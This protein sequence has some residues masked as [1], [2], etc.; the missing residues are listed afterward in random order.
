M[1]QP[2]F[3]IE[4]WE[5]FGRRIAGRCPIPV[6]VGVWPLLGYRQARRINE[7]VAGVVVPEGVQR[8]LETAGAG[9]RNLGF[10]LAGDLLAALEAGGTAAGAYVVAPFK[11]PAQ[12]LEVFERAGA[13]R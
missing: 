11:Q 8:A 6:L 5:A 9:E 13:R 2:F 12:A 7:N 10:Q 4:D 3:A 1:T